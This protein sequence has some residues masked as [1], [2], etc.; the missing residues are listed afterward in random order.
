MT[1][2]LSVA[3][4]ALV[5]LV[6]F[7][8][9][10]D[11]P[12]VLAQE[13]ITSDPPSRYTGGTL[14][15]L[16]LIVKLVPG[17]LRTH[18]LSTSTSESL[19]QDAGT[20]LSFE[21]DISGGG[22]VFAFDS[23]RDPV[24]AERIAARL[25]ARPDVAY[26]VPDILLQTQFVPND[27]HYSRMWNLSG[28][29]GVRAPEAWDTTTG[30][31]SVTV[32]VID[33]GV[34]SEHPDLAA[35]LLPG[36]DFISLNSISNDG[37]GRD[38][39]AADPGDWNG[40]FDCFG[41][42][43]PRGSSWHGTHVIGTIGA[44]GN[45]NTG[46]AGL[47]WGARIV[48]VRAVGRCGGSMSDLIDAL[49]WSAGL[50]VPGV[51]INPWPAD[52][53]N[54][55]LGGPGKCDAAMQS[56]VNDVI[57]AGAVLVVAAGNENKNAAD[58]TPAGCTGGI[59]VAATNRDGGKARFDPQNSLGSNFGA[60]VDISAPGGETWQ[61]AENGIL[62]TFN[63]GK[64]GPETSAYTYYMGT[65]MAAPHVSGVIAL[66][67]AVNPR[68]TTDEIRDIFRATA[69]PF[70]AGGGCDRSICG[71]GIVDA[72]A[73][74]QEARARVGGPTSTPR[75]PGPAPSPTVAPTV[76]PTPG[77]TS[78]PIPT[79]TPPQGCFQVNSS[80]FEPTSPEWQLSGSA[81]V[82]TSTVRSG[83][84]ALALGGDIL[85]QASAISPNT[86]TITNP[87]SSIR[88]TFW[89]L[90]SSNELLQGTADDTLSVRLVD[91]LTQQTL[92]EAGTLSDLDEAS[93]WGQASFTIAP[94]TLSALNNR[95]VRL[96]LN[97]SN[98]FFFPTRA[99]IDDVTLDVCGTQSEQVVS[100]AVPTRPT[101][102]ATR[103]VPTATLLPNMLGRLYLPLA[104]R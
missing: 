86:L 27:T 52:V 101:V 62:S 32:A 84:S 95:Q 20:L 66:M 44:A 90:I 54:V 64:Q 102:T 21:R 42:A 58:M 78:T 4:A 99:V 10:K 49:R 35:R 47:D 57:N 12:S 79:V 65:S 88:I 104:V 40:W 6:C 93:S 29:F 61:S 31:A 3:R 13:S 70:V 59:V 22:Q 60:R 100:T 39:D 30:N 56:A 43:P 23:A 48:P 80:G 37:D 51:P 7:A 25:R 103:P 9:L 26:A 83:A 91:S 75:P 19:S 5:A 98:D 94:S 55:S 87:Q 76:A 8:S 89:Y 74:V 1:A 28:A 45:N 34:R 17:A 16:G 67:H 15:A 63:T 24:D 92:I 72:N 18:S 38:S 97:M 96:A 11:A 73:A 33:T 69:R 77:L 36:Y 85:S 2:R 41:L 71:A 82:V 53:I 14:P 81:R 46:V 50:P 68:L